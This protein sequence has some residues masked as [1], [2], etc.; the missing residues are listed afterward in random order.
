MKK[1]I[2]AYYVVLAFI[3]AC[4]VSV[5][6][7][8]MTI[9]Q[10]IRDTKSWMTDATGLVSLLLPE[11]QQLEPGMFDEQT[12]AV[13]AVLLHGASAGTETDR[14]RITIIADDGTVLGESDRASVGMENHLDRPEIRDALNTGIG[15]Q[16]RR[17]GTTGASYLYVARHFPESGLVVRMAEPLT[18][19]DSIRDGILLYT[20][21][22]IIAGMLLSAVAATLLARYVTSPV[23]RLSAASRKLADGD[24]AVRMHARGDAEL[25]TLSNNINSIAD[26][27]EHTIDELEERNVRVDTIIRS[28]KNGLLAV[29]V[30][31]RI[32]MI[33][34]VVFRM[35]DVVESS[36]VLGQ[37]LVRVFRNTVLHD[38][39]D[40][41]LRD[42]T[43]QHG[44]I[45]LFTDGKR[46][47]DVTA[48]PIPLQ[49]GSTATGG[50][51]V[52]LT[53]VTAVRRLE[54][55]RSAFVSNVTHELKT[56]LTSIRGF[57][58]TLRSG[59]IHDAKVAD[60]FM[61]I[62]DI[63]AD[64]LGSLIDDILELSEI[65]GT[66]REPDMGRFDL[67]PLIGEVRDMLEGTAAARDVRI[68]IPEGAPL[69]VFANRN[70]IKQL[71]INLMDNAVKYNREGGTITVAATRRNDRVEIIVSDTGIGI[72]E[73]H[74]L[75]IFE[76]FYR[77]DKGRSRE[78]GGTGLGLSIVKHIV[79]L[80]NGTIR[81]ESEP[82]KGSA[83]IVTLPV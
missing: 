58:E 25:D 28:M 20:F 81:V 55:M 22:G 13:D 3:V 38:V 76:R 34:P 2:L 51:L 27:L 33:N 10:Y 75:R 39:L 67:L 73:E 50:A 44:E 36:E 16:V 71:L 23:A 49:E 78:Q 52:Y 60:R 21:G 54:E 24:Y 8:E 4:A 65:E 61:D 80:Y 82:G 19:L 69:S 59:A 66:R 6:S 43:E 17:S 68:E 57:V 48:C 72:P 83:F 46:V 37:S 32:Q 14:L 47:L 63:E 30:E 1:R 11:A 29:D 79:Q 31:K 53:D 77:V 64:R 45:L 41:C 35:L 15:S 5:L 9:Q 18:R 40:R 62:I 74:Q 42:N 56:P 12:R 70:R 26:K 7:Y